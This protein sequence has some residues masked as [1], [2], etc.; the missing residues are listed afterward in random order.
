MVIC[1]RFKSVL[2]ILAL[3]IIAGCAKSST[4]QP[5]AS[6]QSE[7]SDAV[8]SG[9]TH[10]VSKPTPGEEQFRIFHHAATGFISLETIRN[11]A[12]NR[13]TEFCKRKNKSLNVVQET[14]STPP[15]ILGNFPRVELVFE[16][17]AV[18]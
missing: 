6:S 15:H 17:L 4:I 7:F 3:I 9:E 16:C 2:S 10:A 18:K 13:A 11:S 1:Y 5:A 12:E 14:T 8:F